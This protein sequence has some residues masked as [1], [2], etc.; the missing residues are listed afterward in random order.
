MTHAA[1]DPLYLLRQQART[2][3]VRL[4]T[5]VSDL[6]ASLPPDDDAN[7]EL[8]AV[9][10]FLAFN[11]LSSQ[12]P[13]PSWCILHRPTPRLHAPSAY[14][15]PPLSI[16]HQLTWHSLLTP[17]LDMDFCVDAIDRIVV[18]MHARLLR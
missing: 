1:D 11:P 4:S 2:Y 3:E 10:L 15:G 5:P 18:V 17:H 9:Y 16:D 7:D 8:L 6:F 13:F 14:P 12:L